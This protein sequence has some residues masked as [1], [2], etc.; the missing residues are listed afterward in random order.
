MMAAKNVSFM[1]TMA[2]HSVLRNQLTAS[3]WS[4]QTTTIGFIWI[5]PNKYKSFDVAIANGGPALKTRR[6]LDKTIMDRCAFATSWTP[7]DIA[8]W[9]SQTHQLIINAEIL[10]IQFNT[11]IENE[12]ELILFRFYSENLKTKRFLRFT[13]QVSQV[14][15]T[16]GFE[17]S[18]A[19]KS[20]AMFLVVHRK[21]S[22]TQ[23][24]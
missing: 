14:S 22:L 7:M 12:S 19:K 15:L 21:K 8:L 4:P 2:Q 6:V 20:E 16:S 23:I 11:G 17:P 24:Q 3:P 10:P 1:L 18:W 13:G 5:L 9:N